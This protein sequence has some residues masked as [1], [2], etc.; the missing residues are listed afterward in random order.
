MIVQCFLN[1]TGKINFKFEDVYG[2]E[3]EIDLSPGSAV[4]IPPF[5]MHTL[6]FLE[7]S[8]IGCRANTLFFFDYEGQ[9]MAVPDAYSRE[10][11]E[12]LKAHFNS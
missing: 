7:D 11:F 9:R 12:R 1:I 10:S 6:N 3:E 5:V 8:S 4:I 2:G